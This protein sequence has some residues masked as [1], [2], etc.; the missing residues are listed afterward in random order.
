MTERNSLLF[1]GEPMLELRSSSPGTLKK[2]FA[3]DVYNSSV[4][5]KQAFPDNNVQLL[6]AI[7]NDLLS[8]EFLAEATSENIDTSLDS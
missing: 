3:G 6:S 4:Y 7:G 2:S 8:N 1:I 5:L